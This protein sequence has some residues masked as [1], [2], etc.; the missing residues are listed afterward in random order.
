MGGGLSLYGVLHHGIIIVIIIIIIIIII[1]SSSSSSSSSSS[2][3]GSWGDG[4]ITHLCASS[5]K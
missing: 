4:L 3:V 5:R 2:L 1:I